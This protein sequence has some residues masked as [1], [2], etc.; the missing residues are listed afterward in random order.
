MGSIA[1]RSAAIRHCAVS[2]S[3]LP[4]TARSSSSTYPTAGRGRCL[5]R[6]GPLRRCVALGPRSAD[7]TGRT[8]WPWWRDRMGL[9]ASLLQIG[10][11]ELTELIQDA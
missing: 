4:L 9:A 1:L 6:C 11:I 10:K 7:A 3:S 5:D 8:R 2:A